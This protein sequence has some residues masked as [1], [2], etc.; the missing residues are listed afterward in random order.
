[1]P[2]HDWTRVEAGIFHAFHMNWLTAISR[3]LNHGLLPSDYY[4]LPEQ[5]AGGFGP[6]VLTLKKPGPKA[7]APVPPPAP[8]DRV[9]TL[10]TAPPKVRVRTRAEANRYA[11]KARIL[12]IRH[13]SRH[14]VV[15]MIEIVSPGNK[16]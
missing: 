15:A 16:N 12:T 6:D 11:A 5:I 8:S 2:I 13:V 1:M 7:P 4:A 14:Q 3:A 9:L 10:A